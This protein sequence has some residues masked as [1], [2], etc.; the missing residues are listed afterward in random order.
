MAK[1]RMVVMVPVEVEA[2]YYGHP[3]ALAPWAHDYV[4]HHFLDRIESSMDKPSG[5]SGDAYYPRLMETSV[6]EDDDLLT[7]E[8]IILDEMIAPGGV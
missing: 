7:G 1:V 3:K 6:T 4:A 8:R 2:E 5:P